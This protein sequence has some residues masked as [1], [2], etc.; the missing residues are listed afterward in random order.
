MVRSFPRPLPPEKEHEALEN[1]ALGDR[2]ARELLIRHNLRLVAH[3][4]KKYNFNER[5]VEDYISIGIV[6]LIK[7]IDS[8][9]LSKGSRLATYAS[10]CIE[11]EILMTMRSSRKQNRE[12]YLEDSIGNDKEGNEIHLL[13]ILENENNDYL[14]TMILS[15]DVVHLRSIMGKVLSS[16]ELEILALRYGFT[17]DNREYTQREVAQR[18]QISRSYVSRI[19][20][21]AI[22]K[23]R[24]AFEERDKE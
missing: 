11:N 2:E 23:L 9:D 18:F 15:E 14:S 16:R 20:K 24:L 10:R 12:V 22:Q 19:E 13:D 5:D 6:G 4:I 17:P 8:Y 21:K 3:V 7:A 1:L